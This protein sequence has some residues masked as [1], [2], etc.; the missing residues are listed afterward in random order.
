MQEN[1]KDLMDEPPTQCHRATGSMPLRLRLNVFELLA[2]CLG[3]TSLKIFQNRI[4]NLQKR[5]KVVSRNLTGSLSVR[6]HPFPYEK[7]SVCCFGSIRTKNHV[8]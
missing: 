2:Q 8:S 4:Q 1:H 6:N 5:E 3:G 7:V